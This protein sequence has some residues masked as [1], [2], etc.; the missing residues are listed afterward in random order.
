[1]RIALDA[2][3]GD[4][5]PEVTI[6]GALDAARELD[7]HVTL[8]G[9]PEALGPGALAEAEGLPIEVVYAAEVVGMHE[10]PAAAV[11]SKKDSSIVVG[12]RLVKEGRADAFVS[13]GNSGAVMAA[14][15]L[16]L[17]RCRGI[18]RPGIGTV[19]PTVKGRTLLLDAGANADVRAENLLQFGRMGSI[20]V[21]LLSGSARPSVGLLSNGEEESK[22]NALTLAAHALLRESGLNF[23]GNV[24]GRDI[25]R[26]TT[27]VVVSDG[28]TGNVA[29]KAIEGTAELIQHVLRE[30]VTR[31]LRDKLAAA[32]LRR[33]FRRVAA[34][35]DYSETGGAPLLGVNGLVFISHGRSNANAI[36]NALRVANEAAGHD[37]VG[38][39]NEAA[40][41]P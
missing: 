41:A 31:G 2:M 9:R 32:L 5:A 6:Q 35:L 13:A 16:V 12:M 20:Y 29:L 40:A 26:G 1:V 33:A 21:N 24:E 27:D 18:D 37:V 36:R 30:E 17:G 3:G 10:H 15:L 14:A 28:F 23:A 19:I 8:V 39:I 25:L 38:A 4:K 22:G 7:I 11:R 34:R